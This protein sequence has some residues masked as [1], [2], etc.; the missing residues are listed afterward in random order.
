MGYIP[1]YAERGRKLFRFDPRRAIIEIRQ[2]GVVYTVDLYAVTRDGSS[3]NAVR[4]LPA[5][6]PEPG[7][8]SPEPT[9]D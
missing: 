8:A 7:A 3:E 9:E 1:V 6:Q 2:R 4:M 5:R